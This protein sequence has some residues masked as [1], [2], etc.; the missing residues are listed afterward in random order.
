MIL[1]LAVLLA[2]YPPEG[3]PIRPS[4]PI[5][6]MIV[7]APQLDL[8]ADA[9]QPM[10]ILLVFDPTQASTQA[11]ANQKCADRM[12]NANGLNPVYG[13]DPGMPG[14][15]QLAGCVIATHYTDQ[16]TLVADLGWVAH[17]PLIAAWRAATFADFV[18]FDSRHGDFCGYGYQCAAQTGAAWAFTA[19]SD[20]CAVGNFSL[21]HE[22]GHNLC[23][24][25]D[26]PNQSPS[27]PYGSGFCDA[28]HSRRDPMTYPSPCGGSR[29]P[30]FGNP[31]ISPF[32][33]P[34][35]DALTA[36][37]ARV[38]REQWAKTTLFQPPMTLINH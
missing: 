21:A 25:H 8:P 26:L 19:V 5:L 11:I 2:Q 38:A 12:T 17:D 29:V 30:Y 18:S 28:A 10:R 3:Q 23:L 37:N 22:V 34:F 16:S 9:S 27:F 4:I 15:F 7:P 36:D 20:G 32:G 35:G 24:A 6:F 13:N 14:R 31:L 1:L 33:Y